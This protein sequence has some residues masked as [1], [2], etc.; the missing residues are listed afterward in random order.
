M[1]V[2]GLGAHRTRGT[3]VLGG[4]HFRDGATGFLVH[5]GG[6]LRRGLVKEALGE[7]DFG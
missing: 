1:D 7:K 3:A 4:M 6:S 2:V 5:S